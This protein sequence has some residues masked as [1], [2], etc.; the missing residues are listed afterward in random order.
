MRATHFSGN[1]QLLAYGQR[2]IAGSYQTPR[3]NHFSSS[4]HRFL[5]LSIPYRKVDFVIQIPNIW[6]RKIEHWV[7]YKSTHTEELKLQISQL[8]HGQWRGVIQG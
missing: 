5:Q 6:I 7:D 3:T 1:F 8:R 2:F 4:Y